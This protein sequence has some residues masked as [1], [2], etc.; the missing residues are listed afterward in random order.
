[1]KTTGTFL[2]FILIT[3]SLTAQNPKFEWATS[4]GDRTSLYGQSMAVDAQGNVYTCGSIVYPSDFDPGP[5]V[6]T[7]S[8]NGGYDAF[9]SKV[10]PEGQLIW[11]KSFGGTGQDDGKSIILD[12]L[13][14]V[15]ITGK[16][17]ET[18]DFDPGGGSF[19]ISSIS[20]EDIF[21]LKL[22]ASGRFIWAKSFEG[23]DTKDVNCMACDSA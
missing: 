1:M 13:G 10:N 4:F 20:D 18:V 8:T 6:F 7:L 16:F 23:V 12:N 22:D 3:I 15:I 19:Q 21:I 9:V 17:S 14:N 2:F 5:G 11:A